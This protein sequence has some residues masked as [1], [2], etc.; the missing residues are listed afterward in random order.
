MSKNIIEAKDIKRVLYLG[1]EPLHILK[2]I[3]VTIE[4]GK[5]IALMGPSGSG[6]S[7]L[8][9]ILG[10]IDQADSGEMNFD[11][12]NL[13]KMS[14]DK[15]ASIR[16]KNIGIVFQSFNLIQTLTAIENVEIPLLVNRKFPNSRKRAKEMLAL[17]GLEDRAKHL[18][19]QLSGGQQQRVAIARALVTQPELIIADEPTGNLDSKTGVKIMELFQKLQKELGITLVVATHDANIASFADQ[20]INIV[21]GKVA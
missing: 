10:G 20:I 11:G 12:N 13:T 9:G 2:G 4:E 5:F 14:E 19:G 15:L 6:K 1:K 18:P 16:N 7:T 8:L 3:D 21:D 17:V